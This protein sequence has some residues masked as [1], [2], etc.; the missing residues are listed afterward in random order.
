MDE[1][2]PKKECGVKFIMN[3][4]IKEDNKNIFIGHGD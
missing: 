3:Q 4:T 1:R 2:L